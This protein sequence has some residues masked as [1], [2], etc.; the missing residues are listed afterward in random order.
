M[1]EQVIIIG[2]GP[3]G[4]TAA[5]Y[6]ARAMLMPLLFEGDIQ[7]GGQLTTT[8]D[9]ENYP[10]Y[11]SI[12]GPDLVEKMREQA[13]KAG[14]RLIDKTV[15]KVD[16]N[17]DQYKVYIGDKEYLT[18]SLIIA[19]GASANRLNLPGEDRL[20]QRGISACAVCD[21]ALPYYRNKPL[22]VIGGGDSAIEEALYLSKYASHVYIL[23]RKDAMRASKIMQHKLVNHPKITILYNTEAVEVLGDHYVDGLKLNNGEKLEITGLF[24]AIG[25][26]PNTSFLDGQVRLDDNGYIITKDNTSTN[27]P[28]VFAAG[29]VRDSIY[30]QAITSAADGCKA[31]LDVEHYL[32]DL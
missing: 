30:R 10:G 19:T 20:W 16:L 1:V 13:I 22:A 32:R 21:G 28:G 17:P 14:A 29:D 12:S 18:K 3:A 6:A 15:I 26:T 11:L 7:P 9:V 8:T 2:S 4:Y 27:V 23:V 5:I 31:A 25:H 24:Y